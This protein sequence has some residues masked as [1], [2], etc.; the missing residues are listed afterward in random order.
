MVPAK[1]RE[2]F[3]KRYGE[4][5]F[6]RDFDYRPMSILDYTGSVSAFFVHYC[7]NCLD[8]KI[9]DRNFDLFATR[10]EAERASQDIRTLRKMK[11]AK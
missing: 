5:W 8:G 7:L 6:L 9:K 4:F 10:E 1:N 3:K 11:L 2:L